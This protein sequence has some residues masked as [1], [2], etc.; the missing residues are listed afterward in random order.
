MDK[1][2]I[3]ASVYPDMENTIIAW[4]KPK[5]R[6]RDRQDVVQEI[7][8][9]FW[10]QLDSLMKTHRGEYNSKTL[11]NWLKVITNRRI[12]DYVRQR[13]RVTECLY[14]ADA[15]DEMEWYYNNLIY[16]N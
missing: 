8:L 14:T 3:F 12:T 4:V 15:D 6:V 16:G 7:W 9:S 5:V 10:W 11:C 1:D 2:E 13:T